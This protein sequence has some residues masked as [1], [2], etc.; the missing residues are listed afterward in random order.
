MSSNINKIEAIQAKILRTIVNAPWYVRNEDVRRDLGMRTV[1]E[2]ISS[3]AER[4]KAR[5]GTHP[6]Q[7]AAE[8]I[9]TLN[10]ERRLKRKHPANLTKDIT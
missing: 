10:M 8:T 4:Y 7:L 6:N 3:Y 9:N 1:R 5:R 2:A